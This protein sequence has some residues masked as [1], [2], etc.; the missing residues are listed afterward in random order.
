MLK[1]G[2]ARVDVTPPIGSHL[3]GNFNVRISKG[4]LDPIELNAIA[5]SDGE[6]KVVMI[7]ADFLGISTNDAEE[8]KKLI[9]KK[10]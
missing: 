10:A 9:D 4:W 3:D 8:I 2:F 6:R 7:A 5:L 1:A